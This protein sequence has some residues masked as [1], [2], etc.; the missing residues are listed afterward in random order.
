MLKGVKIKYF[1]WSCFTVEA[2]NKTLLF[3]PFFRPMHGAHWASLKDFQNVKLICVTHGHYEHYLDTAPIVKATGAT[4]ISS[5][6]VCDHLK[7]R[8]KVESNKL[9]CI[10]PFQQVEVLGFKI[11]AFKWHHRY[12]S[13]YKFFKGSVTT[14]LQFAYHGLIQAPFSAPAF[15]YQIQFPNGTRLMNYNEGFSNLV[16]INELEEFSSKF[17]PDILLAGMQ[18]NF[19]DYL[20]KGVFALKPKT[21]ILFHPHEKLFEKFKLQSSSPKIFIDR[22]KNYLPDVKIIVARPMDTLNISN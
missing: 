1:G 17:C 15:G 7:D 13:F 3:D 14:A 4:V 22:I 2:E 20:A 10:E 8:Y 19:E 12:I 18:L 11:T 21:I 6:M 9:I 5:K 16:D